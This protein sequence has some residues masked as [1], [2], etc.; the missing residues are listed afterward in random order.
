MPPP[1]VPVALASASNLGKE[2][3]TVTKASTDKYK[4][5]VSLATSNTQQ[6][7]KKG[8]HSSNS[9]LSSGLSSWDDVSKEEVGPHPTAS[10]KVIVW[11]STIQ[12][13]TT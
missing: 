6:E 5:G 13:I 3:E 1:F 7:T 2:R 4:C 9:S 8:L 11:N 10:L 12:R